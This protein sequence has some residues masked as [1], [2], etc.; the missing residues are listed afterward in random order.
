MIYLIIKSNYVTNR[1]QWD[2]IEEIQHDGDLILQDKMENVCIGD[3]YEEAE[4]V[5]YGPRSK[6]NDDA[7]PEELNTIWDNQLL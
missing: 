5:F 7:M 4:D 6:P 3:W 2:G 1:I